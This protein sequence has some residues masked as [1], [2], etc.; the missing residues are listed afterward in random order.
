M[1]RRSSLLYLLSGASAFFALGRVHPASAAPAPSKKVTVKVDPRQSKFVP[2]VV[3]INLNDTV[4]WTNSSFILHTVTF[5]PALAKTPGT[6]VLPAGVSPFD[7]G[8]LDEGQ[9]YSHQFRNRGEYKYMC[10]F[11]QDMQMFGS[12]IVK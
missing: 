1:N 9:T 12:V 10:K 4:E 5:D 11:H 8:S 6:V 7:S 2:A 3:T